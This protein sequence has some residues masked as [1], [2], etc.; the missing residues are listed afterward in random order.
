MNQRFICFKG[1]NTESFRYLVCIH[2]FVDFF[3]EMTI[4]NL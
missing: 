1:K 2:K 4:N 3:Y